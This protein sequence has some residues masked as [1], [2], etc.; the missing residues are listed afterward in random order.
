MYEGIQSEVISTTR[1]DENSDLSKTYLGRT[2]ITRVSKIK[3][4]ER[5]PISEQG[6]MVAR[7]LDEQ[8]VRY[9]W[10]QEPANPLCPNHIIYIVNPY[11]HYQNLHLNAQIIQ[12]GNGQFISV[13]FIIP[14]IIDIH[15]HRFEIY[16]LVSKYMTM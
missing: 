12:V 5:F 9:Y 16:P 4:E 14:M 6:Y 15:N 11:I 3:V 2:N 1:I 10:I 13:L 7:L 8:N